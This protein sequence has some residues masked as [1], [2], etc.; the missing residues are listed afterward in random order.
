MVCSVTSLR[1]EERLTAG[2]LTT[3]AG[4]SRETVGSGSGG[5]GEVSV[6]QSA[7]TEDGS[8]A[9]TGGRDGSSGQPASKSES[10][11]Q[12]TTASP[13]SA[14]PPPPSRSSRRRSETSTT[15]CSLGAPSTFQYTSYSYGVSVLK[16]ALTY[17]WD[18]GICPL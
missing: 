2:T 17:L 4:S 1:E 3:T 6:A 13:D 15:Y 9:E 16:S 7:A 5:G 11:A 18:Q 10:P 8:T 12:P 14:M